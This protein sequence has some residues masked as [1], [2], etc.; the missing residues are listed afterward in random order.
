MKS[1]LNIS[2]IRLQ[3]LAWTWGMQYA[4]GGYEG[5]HLTCL[6]FCRWSTVALYSIPTFKSWLEV[7]LLN[8]LLIWA[9]ASSKCWKCNPGKKCYFQSSRRMLIEQITMLLRA[10]P[11]L[12][13]FASA[14]WWLLH[15][16]DP[17]YRRAFVWCPNESL[18]VDFAF[19]DRQKKKDQLLPSCG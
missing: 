8:T 7:M 18:F 16:S 4:I 5:A 10:P 2:K 1:A 6:T 3:F 14:D 11:Y 19:D 15:N 12:I 13:P 9:P 17:S